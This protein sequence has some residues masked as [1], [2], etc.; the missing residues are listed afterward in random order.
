MDGDIIVMSRTQ[1]QELLDSRIE[2]LEQ[3]IDRCISIV[4]ST[5]EQP[6]DEVMTMQQAEQLTGYNRGT[7]YRMTSQQEIPHY[8]SGGKL[9]FKRSELE[10]WLLGVRVPTK[11]EVDSMATTYLVTHKYQRSK[12]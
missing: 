1:L 9:R 12:V 6:K 8:K 10:R 4:Q 2:R 11:K 5:Q 7:L 3:M